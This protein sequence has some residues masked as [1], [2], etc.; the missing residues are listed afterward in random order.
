MSLTFSW[1]TQELL[2]RAD[3]AIEHSIE[4][5]EQSAIGIAQAKKWMLYVELSL[6]RDR[7]IPLRNS[8]GRK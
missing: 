6:Y 8:T 2:D 1:E 5:R 4:A 3:K 7:A